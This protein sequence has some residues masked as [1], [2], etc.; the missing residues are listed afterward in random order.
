LR[1]GRCV[2]DE[3][4]ERVGKYFCYVAD[5]AGIQ[6]DDDGHVVYSGKIKP[7]DE[8]FFV[9]ISEISDDEKRAACTRFVY[10]LQDN[11]DNDEANFCLDNYLMKLS[12]GEQWGSANSYSFGNIS[13]QSAT[14]T[15]FGG[16]EFNMINAEL[17]GSPYVSK[18]KCER[19]N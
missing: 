17:T 9:T 5:M 15:L 1:Y 19:I 8:K 2:K 3:Q 13:V 7:H 4:K 16:G 10:G 12:T 11:F 14:F 18:G 6:S